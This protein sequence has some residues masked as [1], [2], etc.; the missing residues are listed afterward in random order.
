MIEAVEALILDLLEWLAG[1]ERTYAEVMDAWR[2]SCPK[3]PVWEDANDRGL[4][5]M[6]HVSGR[7]IVRITSSG[8]AL[9]DARRPSPSPKPHEGCE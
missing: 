2:T 4:I 5:T 8:R 6:E 3:L 9:L 7:S 1:H